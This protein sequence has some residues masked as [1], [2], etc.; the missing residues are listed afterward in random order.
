M[1]IAT[2]SKSTLRSGRSI[3]VLALVAASALIAAC[4]TGDDPAKKQA[5][6]VSEFKSELTELPYL[7][8]FDE[9]PRTKENPGIVEGTATN[10]DGVSTGFVLSFG[11]EAK[12]LN[13]ELSRGYDINRSLAGDGFWYYHAPEKPGTPTKVLLEEGRIFNSISD[14]GCQVTIGS[15]C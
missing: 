3:V 13:N 7:F 15:K 10:D 5:E 6:Y 12:S 4:G 9:T 2:R 1:E 14:V 11:P 8:R